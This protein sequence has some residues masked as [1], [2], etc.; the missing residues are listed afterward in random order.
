LF[1]QSTSKHVALPF[2]QNLVHGENCS[3][4]TTQ[5]K[6]SYFSLESTMSS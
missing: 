3:A 5:K 6:I 4:E 2:G 1:A